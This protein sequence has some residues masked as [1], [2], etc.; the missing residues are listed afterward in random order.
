M[1]CT[2]RICFRSFADSRIVPERIIVAKPAGNKLKALNALMRP[3]SGSM[4][5]EHRVSEIS[6]CSAIR[7]PEGKLG[8]SKYCFKGRSLRLSTFTVFI[9]QWVKNLLFYCMCSSLT[10]LLGVSSNQGTV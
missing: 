10:R 4:K 3:G 7:S 6:C 1:G 8:I 2:L 9:E 5:F